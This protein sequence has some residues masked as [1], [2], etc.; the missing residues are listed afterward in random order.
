MIRN[1]RDLGKEPGSRLIGIPDG[2]PT[3]V[4]LYNG[5]MAPGAV[6]HESAGGHG[7]EWDHAVFILEGHGTIVCDGK[8]FAVAEGDSVLVP[9]NCFHQWRNTSDAP[10]LRVTFNALAADLAEH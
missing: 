9:P 3:Y 4:M 8:E 5:A 1:F 7:H 2:A 6:S 10:M